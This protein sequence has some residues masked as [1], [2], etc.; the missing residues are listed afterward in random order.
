MLRSIISCLSKPW[1]EGKQDLSVLI[2]GIHCI[3]VLCGGFRI[4]QSHLVRFVE[5]LQNLHIHGIGIGNILIV[6]TICFCQH[7][8]QLVISIVTGRLFCIVHHV[9]IPVFEEGQRVGRFSAVAG[10]NRFLHLFQ[11]I[12]KS[13]KI[14]NLRI[15]GCLIS[16]PA[17]IRSERRLQRL[18]RLRRRI[19]GNLGRNR[20]NTILFYQA[21]DRFDCRIISVNIFLVCQQV[22]HIHNQSCGYK[23]LKTSAVRIGQDQVA[24]ITCC[25]TGL[26][27]GIAAACYVWR[28]NIQFHIK[29]VFYDFCKPSGLNTLVVCLTVKHINGDELIVSTVAASCAAGRCCAASG[30]ARGIAGAAAACQQGYAHCCA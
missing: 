18:A 22:C 24:Q 29:F 3:I 1:P 12:K 15:S 13:V 10:R 7:K 23:I 28:D 5:E 27:Q 6:R 26:E 20:I 16:I 25:G 30:A 4:Y 17:Y 8:S 9:S 11:D 19:A 21:A 2:L 14:L